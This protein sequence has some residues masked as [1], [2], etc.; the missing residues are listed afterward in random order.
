[1]L[2]RAS[3][4]GMLY[5]KLKGLLMHLTME[6]CEHRNQ[7]DVMYV[8]RPHTLSLTSERGMYSTFSRPTE[9]RKGFNWKKGN[10]KSVQ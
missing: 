1:M 3:S 4:L 10:L 6:F 2:E 8:G 9:R 7:V 5:Q